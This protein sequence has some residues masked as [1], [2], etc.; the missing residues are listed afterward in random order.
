[1][2]KSTLVIILGIGISVFFL[3]N[4]LRN[5]DIEEVGQALTS[6]NYCWL[7]LAS[8][9]YFCAYP[10]RGLRWN[11]ILLPIKKCRI[12]DLTSVM[13]IAFMANNIFPLRIGEI[14]G[15]YVLAKKEGISKSTSLATVVMTR[16]FD[17]IAFILYAPIVLFLLY[18]HK[19]FGMNT[20][21]IPWLR[22]TGI[23]A[24]AIFVGSLLFLYGMLKKRELT[25]NIFRRIFFFTGEKFLE[26]LTGII[27]SFIEGLTVLRSTKHVTMTLLSSLLVWF[28]EGTTFY[29]VIRAFGMGLTYPMAFF[30][31]IV[32][33]MGVL[34]PSSPGFIGVYEYFCIV[35][36]ALFGV[37]K[38]RALTYSLVTHSLQFLLIIAMGFF[39][40]SR[41]GLS[42]AK[43]K[44]EV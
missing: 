11:Y 28:F 15:A 8:F 23:M 17:G 24:I 32:V 27:N 41:E 44:K 19:N 5:V 7:V 40:L 29:L 36:M 35:G 30:V 42:L 1:M 12:A 22:Y 20:L 3:F 4:A 33:G 6:V 18:L 25:V 43:L 9:T 26:R 10:A 14:V 34:L 13:C 38:S 31:M 39:C 2:K 16:V 37:E 21:R